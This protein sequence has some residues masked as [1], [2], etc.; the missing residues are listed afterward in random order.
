M[1]MVSNVPT[2]MYNVVEELFWFSFLAEWKKSGNFLRSMTNFLYMAGPTKH[3]TPCNVTAKLIQIPLLL[4]E[5][6]VQSWKLM[7]G[8][9]SRVSEPIRVSFYL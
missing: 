4:G 1:D 9:I 3:L 7:F 6:K 5:E 8:A 2:V